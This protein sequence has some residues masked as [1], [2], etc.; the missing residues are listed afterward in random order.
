MFC[1]I[2]LDVLS[3]LIIF[4]VLSSRRGVYDDQNDIVLPDFEI[5]VD[6]GLIVI[7]DVILR[8]ENPGISGVVHIV[9]LLR[10]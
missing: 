8:T 10:Q 2:Q 4:T 5:I 1:D 9:T 6:N 3:L 7:R